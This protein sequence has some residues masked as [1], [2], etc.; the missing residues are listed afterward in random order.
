MRKICL[1][2]V[3][4]SLVTLVQAQESK[5]SPATE[6]YRAGH[7][8]LRVTDAAQGFGATWQFDRADNGDNRIVRDERR[9]EAVTSGSVLS[10]CDDRA[11]LMTGLTPGRG[12]EMREIDEPVLVLQLVLRLLARAAPEGPAALGADKLV[13]ITEKAAPIRVRKGLEARREFNAPWQ[14]RGRLKREAGGA[15]AFDLVF[16]HAGDN[17]NDPRAELALAGVWRQNSGV[18]SFADAMP[19]ADWQVY[20]VNAVAITTGGST[21]IESMSTTRPL[22][23]A[24]LGH[25]RRHIER[26]WSMNPKVAPILE[27]TP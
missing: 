25:L 12:R 27:C 11:L 21:Q 17:A 2:A 23:Y 24:T 18:A 1:M 13:E 20:R 3:L 16:T 5:P 22:R 15:V 26:D 8:M 6:W 19:V 10:V 14:A 4:C 9:G 7:V